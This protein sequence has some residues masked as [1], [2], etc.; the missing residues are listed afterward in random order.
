MRHRPAHLRR[1]HP[2]HRRTLLPPTN[3]LNQRAAVDTRS[4]ELAVW[5]SM[6]IAESLI[7]RWLVL[8]RQQQQG[9]GY[10]P[11]AVSLNA[12]NSRHVVEAVRDGTAQV[13]FVEG[14][15]AST[16][17]RSGTVAHD[18]FVLVTASRTPLSRRRTALTPD[19]VAGLALTSREQGSGTR[20]VL[21]IALAKHVP[22]AGEP[23][24][25]VTTATA[26][27]EPVIAGSAPAFLSRRVARDVGS[28]SLGVV[29]VQD[30]D[31]RRYFRAVWVG[32][33]HPPAGA[34]RDVVAIARATET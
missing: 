4:R 15:E 19:E 5:A 34:V 26:I 22:M 16:G 3:Q 33:K 29:A 21:G 14:V 9:E 17:V 23:D 18:E 6:T 30:L 32:N 11:T 2:G 27:R 28:G 24:V 1:T 10:R 12:A 20:E 13:G 31:L 7:P 8:L 25:E